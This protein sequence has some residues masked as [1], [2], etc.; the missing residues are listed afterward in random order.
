MTDPCGTPK[1]RSCGREREP[2]MWTRCCL[3]EMYDLNHWKTAPEMPKC[4]CSRSK[5]VEWSMVSKAADR[6]KDGSLSC[7]QY[8][9]FGVLQRSVLGPFLFC[10]STTS[11]NRIIATHDVSHHMWGRPTKSALSREFLCCLHIWKGYLLSFAVIQ[12]LKSY[13]K[14]WPSYAT[15]YTAGVKM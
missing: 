13:S 14:N 12:K 15:L 3:F 7:P 11:I 9:H 2:S 1:W 8:L 10:L 4:P 6:S 5:R